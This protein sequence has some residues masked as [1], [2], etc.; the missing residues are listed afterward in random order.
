MWVMMAKGLWCE[1]GNVVLGRLVCQCAVV[2]VAKCGD[3]MVGRGFKG[4][5][6]GS[7]AGGVGG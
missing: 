3:L 6:W 1:C 2:T 7:D 5:E 4:R